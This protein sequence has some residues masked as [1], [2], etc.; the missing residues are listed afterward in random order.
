MTE[1]SAHLLHTLYSD[2]HGW[3]HGWL[4]RKL[5]DGHDAADL[6]QDTFVRLIGSAEAQRNASAIREPRSFL[7]TIAQRVMVDHFRRRSL[8]RAYCEALAAMPE[9]AEVSPETRALV[10]ETLVEIDAMLDRLG[11]KAKRA[12]LLSQ[13]EGFTYAQIA[14]ELGVSVSSVKKYMAK[15]M[16]HC[17]LLALDL[18]ASVEH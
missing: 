4:R 9:P 10:F 11:G 17:L 18:D 12:F 5:G 3:L 15:A 16:E 7:A 2:H 13:L 1:S 6:A 14:F 8:E